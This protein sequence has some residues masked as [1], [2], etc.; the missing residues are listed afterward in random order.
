MFFPF[1]HTSCA[2]THTNM[3]TQ[4]HM[5]SLLNLLL[6]QAMASLMKG[7]SRGTKEQTKGG[8]EEVD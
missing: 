4:T 3:R 7:P 1:K 2:R 6:L 5:A 8:E